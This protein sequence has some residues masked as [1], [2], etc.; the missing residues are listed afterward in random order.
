MHTPFWGSH[1]AT[2][3]RLPHD[4]HVLDAG[5]ALFGNPHT[6]WF[7]ACGLEVTNHPR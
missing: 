6:S 4:T 7:L 3:W 1:N 2:G 5:Q